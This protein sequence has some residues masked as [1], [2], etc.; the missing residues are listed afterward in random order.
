MVRLAVLLF[1]ATPARAKPAPDGTFHWRAAPPAAG[2]PGQPPPVPA[3]ALV[4]LG[5]Q[6]Y[7]RNC[8]A[9]HGSDGRGDGPVA[10]HLVVPPR[11]FTRA[12]FKVRSTPSGS[13]PTD[14]DLFQT[15]SRGMHGTDMA[16]WVRLSERQRWALVAYLKSL[17]PRFRDE[18]LEPAVDIPASPRG[19][20]G[21]RNRGEALYRQLQCRNCHGSLGRGDGP[22]VRAYASER[23]VR[24]RDLARSYFVR[25][26]SPKDIYLTL[27]TGMDGTPMGAFELPSEDLWGLAYYVRDVL[28]Q[29]PPPEPRPRAEDPEAVPSH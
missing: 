24:I 29:P 9:C 19:R 22:G 5:A 6:L 21:L 11:D 28:R 3:A 1:L 26:D 7:G 27:R 17:S 8:A 13:L 2:V 23:D 25:G 4:D 20:A 10:S 16:P 15:I 14:L 12:V 18:A